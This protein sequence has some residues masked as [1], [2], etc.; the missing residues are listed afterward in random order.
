M[1]DWLLIIAP[2]AITIYFIEYPDQFTGIMGWLID[3]MR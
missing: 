1:Q 3:W 2:L